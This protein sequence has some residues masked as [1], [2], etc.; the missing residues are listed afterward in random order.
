VVEA[1]GGMAR[2]H[3]IRQVVGEILELNDSDKMALLTQVVEEALTQ[4][5]AAA[6]E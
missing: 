1:G 2:Q 5:E 4:R 3:I 6:K